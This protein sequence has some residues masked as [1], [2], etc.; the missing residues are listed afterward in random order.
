MLDSLG[1]TLTRTTVSSFFTRYGKDPRR[2]E[3]TV[4]EAVAYL[5]EELWRP[6]S[7]KKRLDADDGM[8]DTS[9]SATPILSTAGA[10]GQELRLDLA[11][12][13]FSG[14]PHV[15]AMGAELYLMPMIQFL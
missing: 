9:V 2:D 1:S 7:E 5:E 12:L 15:V 10:R 13:D 4:D 6:D 3:L 11:D 14:V 8:P